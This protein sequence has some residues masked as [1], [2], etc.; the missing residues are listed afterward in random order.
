[1][2]E[3]LEL[4]VPG[5][6]TRSARRH[7]GA[8]LAKL[9]RDLQRVTLPL[10]PLLAA[11][12]RAVLGLLG[13]LSRRQPG[14]VWSALRRPSVYC[15]LRLA[16]DGAP[17][18]TL[19]HTGLV[20]LAAELAASGALEEAVVLRRAPSRIVLR[21][22]LEEI[23]PRP[24]VALRLAPDGTPTQ[25]GQPCARRR[26]F[27]P[28]SPSTALALADDNPLA[29]LE[30]HPDKTGSQ[31]D[32]GDAPTERWVAALKDASARIAAGLPVLAEELELVVSVIVP[33]GTH[34]ERHLS[35]SYREALG[36]VYVTLHPDPLTMTEAVVHEAQHNK[37]NAVLSVDPLL[38]NLPEE[39]YRSPVRPDPRPL[40]GVLLAVHAFVPVALLYRALRRAG[41]PLVLGARAEA[42]LEA[43]LRGNEEGLEL[44]ERHARPTSAGAELLRE[45]RHWHDASAHAQLG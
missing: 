8:A 1:V 32:L 7:L 26:A 19:L 39:R 12:A 38:E 22:L 24:G 9:V 13:P 43:I 23:T 44:L 14:L 6:D 31:L 11:D 25:D 15:H 41:D 45:L 33:V 2:S 27:I 20:T 16:A 29:S 34:D 3:P 10:D 18:A 28:L 17:D 36:L 42:R 5:S 37:L 4:T 35:A 21:S 30:A 40:L